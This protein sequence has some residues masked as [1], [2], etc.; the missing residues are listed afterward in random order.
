MLKADNWFLVILVMRLL[1]FG[2]LADTLVLDGY[3]FLPNACIL[4]E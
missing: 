1:D 4:V 3:V 2:F